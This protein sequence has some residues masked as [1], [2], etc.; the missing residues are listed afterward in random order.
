MESDQLLSAGGVLLT[1]IGATSY[2]VVL[3]R[4]D[5]DEWRLPKGKL[6]PGE[7]SQGAAVREVQE[8][9]GI[10]A[11]AHDLVGQTEYEYVE[12]HTNRKVRKRVL[13]YLMPMAEQQAITVERTTFDQGLWVSVGEAQKLLTFA[14]ERRI[15]QEA[16]T[17]FAG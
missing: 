12:P 14:A 1:V 17:R 10:T 13:Y 4:R 9:T 3:H 8:E 7:T 5:P 11:Q 16:A 6:H 2:T 15:V